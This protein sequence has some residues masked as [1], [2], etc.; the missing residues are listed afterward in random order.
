MGDFRSRK[1]KKEQ[2]NS[3][4]V[5]LDSLILDKESNDQYRDK[6]LYLDPEDCYVEEQ[7]RKDISEHEIA[8]R[9]ASMKSNGQLQPIVVHP[10]DSQ[11]K[12]LID[13]GECRWRAAK[14]IENFKIKAIV[15][16]EADDRS[17]QMRIVGQLVENE[18]R[19]NLQPIEVG[20]ALTE[21]LQSG[22][23]QE[24]VAREIGWITGSGKPN[25]NK[26]SRI[27]GLLK[28]PDDGKVL[29]RKG[30]I[31]DVLALETLRKVHDADA[32]AYGE[33]IEK[34]RIEG[35]LSRQEVDETYRKARKEQ[36]TS[37]QDMEKDGDV[38]KSDAPKKPKP[39][40]NVVKIEVVSTGEIGVLDIKNSH[41]GGE[42]VHAWIDGGKRSVLLDDLRLIGVVRSNCL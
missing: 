25:I 10:P 2:S 34:A 21:L 13:K 35:G 37:K 15:D 6:V 40:E 3:S 1:Q 23:T 27:A 14:R 7:V 12:Y 31:T 29:A 5:N 24:E 36:K 39:E 18:Q 42:C 33:L 22:M 11:G 20:E 16:Y 41:P 19:A 32:E 17:D 26:V 28:L 8:E 4:N 30:V 38:K 9:E